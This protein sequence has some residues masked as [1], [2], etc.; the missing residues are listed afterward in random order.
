V[1]L[2]SIVWIFLSSQN[3]KS[4]FECDFFN[5]ILIL[6]SNQSLL[7]KNYWTSFLDCSNPSFS[8][9][10]KNPALSGIFFNPI[11]ILFSNQSLLPKNYWTSFFDCSNP[12]FSAKTKNP[13]LSGIFLIQFWFYFQINPSYLKTIERHF[14]L[15]ESFFLA[16]TKNPTLSAIFLIQFWFYFQ[17]NPCYL[18]TIERHFSIVRIPLSPLK[19]R[20]PRWVGFF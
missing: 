17:I 7:P 10:T 8:A 5:P 14:R 12:S 13:A 11:L 19:L 15:F 18:K 16:K 1:E 4:Y 3:Q 9:K 20:I 6:F 2:F